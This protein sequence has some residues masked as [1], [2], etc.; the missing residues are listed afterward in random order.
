M[1][2]VINANG[3]ISTLSKNFTVNSTLS[4]QVNIVPRAAPIGTIVSFQAISPK[5]AFFEWDVG[6]GSPTINGQ[7][8]HITHIYQKTGIYKT[9]LTVKNA[10]GDEI[11]S[12]EKTVYA[13]DTNNPFAIIEMSNPSNTAVE[14]VSACG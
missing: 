11:N 9:R 8:D 12:I 14:D 2:T 1:V 5:A 7:M 3:K 13:T 4:A 10:L 6:D